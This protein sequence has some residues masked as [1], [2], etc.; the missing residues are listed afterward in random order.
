[1]PERNGRDKKPHSP[2]PQFQPQTARTAEQRKT[3]K[4]EVKERFF[5]VCEGKKTEPICFEGFR[6]P[7]R[8]LEIIGT[9][10]NTTTLVDEAIR[11]K[12]EQTQTYDQFWC[13]FDRD[14]FPADAFNSAI[15][16]AEAAGFRVAYTNEA[17]ELWYLLH[18]DDQRSALSRTQYAPILT[19]RL[20][21]AYEKNSRTMYQELEDKQA[22]AVRRAERLLAEYK[23]HNPQGDNPCTTV[24][25]LV[26]ELCRNVRS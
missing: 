24:H 12:Q 20:G 22:H 17:F 4:L 16:K 14:S 9:G 5:I 2:K 10:Y 18:F 25:L 1:M 13:V 7:G 19:Q 6:V 21:H 11:L 23:P 3:D 8:V 15:Q 26:Q